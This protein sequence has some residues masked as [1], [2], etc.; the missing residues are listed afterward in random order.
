M[1]AGP[2]LSLPWQATD[3]RY[4]TLPAQENALSRRYLA[5]LLRWV[6]VAL[7]S[8]APWPERPHCGHF[9]GG[10]YWYGLETSRTI[11]TLAAVATSSEFDP[12]LAGI[13]AAEV[14]Q[15]AWQGL[16]YLCF[17]HDTGPPECVRPAISWG[18]QEPAGSK[19]GERGQGF[20]RESQCGTTLAQLAT[21]AAL[22]HDLVQDEERAMLAAIAADFL[23]RFGT[24]APRSGVY[25]D[26]QTEENGWTAMGLIASLLLSAPHALTEQLWEQASRWLFRATTRPED[27]HDTSFFTAGQTVQQWCDR[28]FTRLPDG[29][30]EN[31]GFVHPTY[32]T[33]ALV[34]SGEILN[35]LHLF[36]HPVPA[37]LFWRRQDCY[38]VLKQWTDM[39]GM[40]HAPQGMDW[41][42]CAGYAEVN[43]AHTVAHL[44]LQDADAALLQRWSLDTLERSR[45]AHAGQAVPTEVS[46]ACH[47]PQDPVLFEET[48]TLSLAHAYL[49]H[50]LQGEGLSPADPQEMLQRFAGVKVYPHGGF[51]L[52]R[53]A[54]GKTSFAWRNR[55]MILPTPPEGIRL[56]GPQSGSLL[57]SVVVSGKGEQTR[58]VALTIRDATDHVGVVLVQDLAECSIRRQ[59]FFASLP[60]GKCLTVERLLALQAVTVEEVV[61]GRFSIMNDP[62]FG[63]APTPRSQ[64]HLFWEEGE[65]I[66][67]GYVSAAAGEDDFLSLWDCRWLNIDDRCGLVF[68][69]SGRTRYCNRHV[70]PVW[71]A[72]DD[73]LILS[74]QDELQVY[75]RGDTIAS[76][77]TLWCPE[78]TREATARQECLRHETP[79]DTVLCEIDGWLCGANF[80]PAPVALPQRIELQPYQDWSPGWGILATTD[81]PVRVTLQLQPYEPLLCQLPPASGQ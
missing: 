64:R 23:E 36:Q 66:F 17:T 34:Q 68:R 58:Q 20:F 76:L 33:S 57:A 62:F 72:V 51:L 73:A 24:M 12:V 1:S 60:D 71:R 28:T 35:L 14:R 67:P 48:K 75:Q 78:Q 27:A 55:T 9:F 50:R 11:V 59:V 25:Y 5:L 69:G 44:S 8:F 19:W 65:Q 16:R 18:R 15:L 47:G 2:F 3:F 54:H 40:L 10:V 52:H 41:P 6:P 7:R 70:F 77:M 43:F 4:V 81:V 39:T 26:T 32:L 80:G 29:T 56:I 13:S 49:A 30:S 74:L 38:T 21:A 22:L 46:Q 31:H 45:L 63:E 37:Q 61:Q 79:P 53:H 42:Y